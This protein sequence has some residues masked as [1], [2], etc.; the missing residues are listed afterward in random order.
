MNELRDAV[1]NRVGKMGFGISS[2]ILL[3]PFGKS[4]PS[5][6]LV[7]AD[8]SY[9]SYGVDKVAENSDHPPL[10]TAFNVYTVSGSV[11]ALLTQRSGFAPFIDGLLGVQTFNTRTKIDKTL[12]QTVI[13]DD[14][15]EVLNTTNDTG[16]NYGLGVGFFIRNA[17][18][19]SNY[20]IDA[21]TPWQI[22]GSFSVRLLYYWGDEIKYVKRN[23]VTV[24]S[25]NFLTFETGRTRTDMLVLQVGFTLY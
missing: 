17:G 13:N 23:S 6:F 9:I 24:T 16:L 21:P 3:N 15:P 18:K 20:A 22:R 5:P 10:K 19:T 7:G 2:G 14:Q 11:R 1:Q 25:D 8:F 12:L 4:K